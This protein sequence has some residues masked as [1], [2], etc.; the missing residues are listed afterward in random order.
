M[1]KKYESSKYAEDPV[2]LYTAYVTVAASVLGI[3]YFIFKHRRNVY[4]LN[5]TQNVQCGQFRKDL[6]TYSLEEVRTHDNKT[7][8]I[9]ITFGEG[10]YDITEFVDKHPGGPS[11]ILMAAGSSIDPFWS[12]FANHKTPEIYSLLESMRIGNISKEDA[13]SG[14]NDL[15][16]PYANEPSRHKALIVN[17]SKPFCAEPPSTVLVESFLT[18]V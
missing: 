9:W 16:D 15:L 17:G 4:A 13:K 1:G 14:E 7:N 8:R 3:S 2:K 11:K 12:I 5:A 18:P 10:V 6:K